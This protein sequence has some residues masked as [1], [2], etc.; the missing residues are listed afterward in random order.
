M[1]PSVRGSL[2]LLAVLALG[3]AACTG[4]SAEAAHNEPAVVV[5]EV[6]GSDHDRLKLSAKAAERLG[7]ETVEVAQ[8]S[9]GDAR[10]TVVP[11][12]AVV[13][14]AHGLTWTYTNPDGLA[15][16]RHAITIDRIDGDSAILSAGPPVGTKVVVVG[17][18]ELWGV[19]NG[20]GGGH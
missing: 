18:A 3:V 15:F 2:A 20:V 1:L 14:D 16:V 19:E 9:G 5:E 4:P 11:Y 17:V 8:G 10:R 7:I 13:Y 12:A 6:P